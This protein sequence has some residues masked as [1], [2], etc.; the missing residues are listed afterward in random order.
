MNM[1]MK[2][3]SHP[4]WDPDVVK[5]VVINRP[6]RGHRHKYTKSIKVSRWDD[7]YM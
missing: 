3:R 1:G 6:W 4:S 5:I 7:I 2:N